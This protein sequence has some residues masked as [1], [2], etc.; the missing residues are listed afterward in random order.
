MRQN[1]PKKNNKWNR[2][3]KENAQAAITS[4]S[5]NLEKEG[6]NDHQE[7]KPPAYA[8]SDLV[9]SIW[10]L[11]LNAQDEL[12]DQLMEELGF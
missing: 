7:N 12:M 3:R 9:K 2:P 10:A 4:N 5:E 6:P 11:D 1:C 8:P